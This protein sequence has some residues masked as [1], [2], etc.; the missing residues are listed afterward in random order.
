MA[1]LNLTSLRDNFSQ[2]LRRDTYITYL[3]YQGH[4]VR[5]ALEGLI[6]M[7]DSRI[8]FKPKLKEEFEKA[9]YM[10]S[11]DMIKLIGMGSIKY[12]SCTV[13]PVNIMRSIDRW[14][15]D[16]EDMS[17]LNDLVQHNAAKI[18]DGKVTIF[19]SVKA[20]VAQSQKGKQYRCKD[21]LSVDWKLQEMIFTEGVLSSIVWSTRKYGIYRWYR[22]NM[23]GI[24]GD[25]KTSDALKFYNTELIAKI[26][27]ATPDWILMGFPQAV[28][29]GMTSL[30]EFI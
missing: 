8:T 26:K 28:L 4:E 1:P 2:A 20:K 11:V 13:R 9:G 10:Q 17:A 7:Y 5:A 22:V 24:Q 27:A 6:D 3:Q 21:V 15:A 30:R 18:I 29:K 16:K 25:V 23:H 12:H 14:E 19:E